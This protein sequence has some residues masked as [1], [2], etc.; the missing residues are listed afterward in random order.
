MK[1][2]QQE[3]NWSAAAEPADAP[4]HRVGQ[5]SICDIAMPMRSTSEWDAARD[6]GLPI[7]RPLPEAV[8]AGVF[9]QLED[10][11]VDPSEEEVAELTENLANELI[12]ALGEMAELGR[13]LRG[14]GAPCAGDGIGDGERKRRLPKNLTGE[15]ERLKRGYADTLAAYEEAFG[16][17]A[18][19]ALDEWVR[20]THA[21]PEEPG[22]I[23]EP[24]HPWHYYRGG[25]NASPVPADEIPANAEAGRVLI[26]GLPVHSKKRE[27]KLR[28]LLHDAS[29]QLED[30][31]R[32]YEDIAS[33]G[34]EALS[35]YDR[36]IAHGGNDELARASAL[37]LKFNHIA[38]G[39]GR[40]ATIEQV[41]GNPAP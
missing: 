10:G 7:P 23:Y 38:W 19:A 29:A 34:A 11:P 31:I 13:A 26:A 37:A 15:I 36:E 18:V 6:D 40:I 3:F 9:G 33:R 30:D 14:D 17:E 5:L 12:G 27:K 8:A 35:K 4:V 24:T 28:E 25:Q 21:D 39:R 32:R 41:L 2:R 1:A 16:T 20:K 22:P